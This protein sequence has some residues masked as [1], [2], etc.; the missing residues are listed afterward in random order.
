M[1][2]SPAA[3]PRGITRLRRLPNWW[4]ASRRLRRA[5]ALRQP[6]ADAPPRT[7]KSRAPGTPAALSTRARA[8][9][10]LPRKRAPNAQQSAEEGVNQGAGGSLAS[11]SNLS[12]LD[13]VGPKAG[14]TLSRSGR[15]QS[16]EQA[17]SRMVLITPAGDEVRPS[18]GTPACNG[19]RRT[20]GAGRG[21]HVRDRAQDRGQCGRRH[22][23]RSSK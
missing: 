13:S 20:V 14:S 1:K 7:R 6:E 5:R 17:L 4:F 23:R 8:R 10:R 16:L 11:L 12:R 19:D 21:H 3:S 22:S 9:Q 15:R 2:S 18:A